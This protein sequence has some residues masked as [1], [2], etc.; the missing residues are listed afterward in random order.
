MRERLS[1]RLTKIETLPDAVVPAVEAAW[2]AVRGNRQDQRSALAQLNTVL[3]AHG[4]QA[5]SR[6]SFG[7]W[8]QR[9]RAGQIP[10]PVSVEAAGARER[11][12]EIPMETAELLTLGRDLIA[13]LQ[14]V[15]DRL[16]RSPASR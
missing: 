9:V 15:L 14:R 1:E 3:A 6:S 5:V 4:L 13:R 8:A 2:V 10:R 11:A 7:R 16:E 12:H